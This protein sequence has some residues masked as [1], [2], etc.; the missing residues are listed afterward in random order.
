[1]FEVQQYRPDILGNNLNSGCKVFRAGVNGVCIVG[2][3]S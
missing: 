1:M 2:R 3:R